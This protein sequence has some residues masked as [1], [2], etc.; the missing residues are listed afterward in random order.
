MTDVAGFAAAVYHRGVG[1]THVPTTLLGMVDAAIGGKTGVNLPE[2]KNLVG[3]F[4]Q[5]HAVLCD[6]D[7]LATLPE[8][9]RLS[10]LGEMAKYHFLPADALLALPLDER[11]AAA[12]ASRREVVAADEREDLAP[13]GGRRRSTT[14]TRWPARARDGGADLRHGEAVAV[15]PGV[16]RRAGAPPRPHRPGPGRRAPPGGAVRAATDACPRATGT[17]CWC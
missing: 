4:W 9:E 5:P 15:G 16:R 17:S 8:R 14:A 11:L 3:A 6:T 2:G 12:S 13:M 7:V 1:V 10:G